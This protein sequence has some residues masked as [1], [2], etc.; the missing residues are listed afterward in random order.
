MSCTRFSDG[1]PAEIFI[2]CL[3]QVGS[4]LEALARAA[5]TASLAFQYG[6]PIDV[7]RSALTRDH[8]GGPATLL[9]AA[10]D[11]LGDSGESV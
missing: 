1:A 8:T 4:P 2:S 6:C 10:I 5:V 9:G 7:L 3:R 11:A